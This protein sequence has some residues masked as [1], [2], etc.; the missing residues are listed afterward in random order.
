MEKIFLL[1]E[2]FQRPS[3]KIRVDRLSRYLYDVYQIL[4]TD[5]AERATQDKEL[6]ETIVKHRYQ[7]TKLGGVDY[8]LHQPQ[9]INPIPN[10][11]I[12]DAWK[13]DYKK[14]Q[15]QMIY[16]ESPEFYEMIGSIKEFIEKIKNINWR[17]DFE[18]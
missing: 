4:K 13:S 12:I 15:E 3:E 10:K 5:F 1:H 14:M 18:F 2:E 6:Y 11:E 16:G 17:M 9:T 8:R 7:F